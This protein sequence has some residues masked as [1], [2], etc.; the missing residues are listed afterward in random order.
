[1]SASQLE[2]WVFP[3]PLRMPILCTCTKL[4]CHFGN[5]TTLAILKFTEIL[6]RS[7]TIYTSYTKH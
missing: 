6:R 2:G 4:S 5:L 1:M 7:L 3:P